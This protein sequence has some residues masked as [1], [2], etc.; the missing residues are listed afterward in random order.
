MTRPRCG[1]R[2]VTREKGNPKAHPVAGV[3]VYR[4]DAPLVFSNA[5]AFKDTGRKLLI[6]AGAKGALPSTM[7]IDCEEYVFYA[8]FTGAAALSDTFL[9]REALRG[10]AL[11]GPAARRGPGDP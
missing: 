2:A 3:I 5:E 4:F 11:A 7:V 10:G 1:S 9:V 8:D 6:D